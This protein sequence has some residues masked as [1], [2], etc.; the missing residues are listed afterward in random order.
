M[1]LSVIVPVYNCT[2]Y[3]DRCIESIVSQSFKEIE[4]ILVDDGS[5]DD[6]G[7]RCDEWAAKDS[8]ITVIHRENGGL[9]AAR[10]TGI[11]HATSE[12]IT[13]VDADDM[14]TPYLLEPNIKILKQ[15]PDIDLLE[16]PI[17]VHFGAP[18]EYT[19][20]FDTTFIREDIFHKWLSA[21]GYTHCYACNKIYKK[22][23]FDTIRFPEGESFEDAAICPS[24]IQKAKCI[25]F[26]VYGKYLYFTNGDGITNRYSFRNQEPLLRHNCSLLE[27]ATNLEYKDT[28]TALWIC[29][30]NLLIDL[31]SCAEPNYSYTKSAASFIDGYRP[32]IGLFLKSKPT[33]KDC[34]K[35]FGATI[36]GVN[37]FT[38]L[39]SKNR[40]L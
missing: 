11:E 37:C 38:N 25:C 31:K 15:N 33:L 40:S 35:Y 4:L 20:Q 34:F 30:L 24:L 16:Y 8:R 10:N 3:I 28:L 19:I 27:T 14:I 39:L 36:I 21:K 1:Y 6:S 22:H 17:E 18:N 29:C 32:S 9:S 7:V 12:Y 26:S 2:Q 5:T 23:L 13:F